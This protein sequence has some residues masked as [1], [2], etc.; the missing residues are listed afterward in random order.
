MRTVGGGSTPQNEWPPN[1]TLASDSAEK[2]HGGTIKA[3]SSPKRSVRSSYERLRAWFAGLEGT[4]GVIR[5][6]ARRKGQGLDSLR[7]SEVLSGPQVVI[8]GTHLR[9]YAPPGAPRKAGKGLRHS[10]CQRI[11][12]D[13]VAVRTRASA[14]RPRPTKFGSPTLAPATKGDHV[15]S[16]SNLDPISIQSRSKLGMAV[17]GTGGTLM[18]HQ[19]GHEH[20][21]KSNRATCFPTRAGAPASR[22]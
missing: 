19:S 18:D 6:D 10:V 20:L 9:G 11:S 7:I 14:V 22:W 15:Q 2:S 3:V 5:W 8:S 4:P 17:S 1:L 12:R 16:R 21:R 13:S